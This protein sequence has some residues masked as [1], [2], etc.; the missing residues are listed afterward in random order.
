MYRDQSKFT[1]IIADMMTR[2]N[3]RLRHAHRV[4]LRHERLSLVRFNGL[5][6]DASVAPL[7][8]FTGAGASGSSSDTVSTESRGGWVKGAKY[9][10]VTQGEHMAESVTRAAANLE[11]ML[12]R[13]PK[14]VL[15]PIRIC[16]GSAR[17][18]RR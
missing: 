18:L 17:Q 4:G 8:R 5:D 1:I 6:P 14:T 7:L 12:D 10:P 11:Q 2:T 3:G 16:A 9:K 13:Y 15:T